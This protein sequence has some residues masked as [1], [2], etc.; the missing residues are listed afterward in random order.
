ME[1]R[2]LADG[3]AVAREGAAII[4]AQARAAVAARGRFIWAVSGAICK[5]VRQPGERSRGSLNRGEWSA[6]DCLS[7]W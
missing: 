2:V 7:R 5:S 3:D 1:I 6:E 4:A